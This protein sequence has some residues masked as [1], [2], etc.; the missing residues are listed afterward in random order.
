MNINYRKG[1]HP[2]VFHVTGH[3]VAL[4]PWQAYAGYDLTGGFV[5]YGRCAQGFVVDKVFGT[6]QTSPGHFA[7]PRTADDMAEYDSESAAAAG[8]PDLMLGYTCVRPK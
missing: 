8:H 6:P 5:L 1:D 3:G 4:R 7:T 2:V